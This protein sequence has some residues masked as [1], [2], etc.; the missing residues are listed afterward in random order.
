MYMSR[1]MFKSLLL[2][3]NTVSSSSKT[4]I[5]GPKSLRRRVSGMSSRGLDVANEVSQKM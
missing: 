5:C 3:T 4:R 1:K 2:G